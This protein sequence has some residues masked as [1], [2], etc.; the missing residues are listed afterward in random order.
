[1]DWPREGIFSLSS[2]FFLPSSILKN[3]IS[4]YTKHRISYG[5]EAIRIESSRRRRAR[6]GSERAERRDVFLQKSLLFAHYSGASLQVLLSLSAD[7][8]LY[9]SIHPTGRLTGIHLL[10]LSW[11]VGINRTTL[12]NLGFVP[13]NHSLGSLW[14]TSFAQLGPLLLI[15]WSD[16]ASMLYR[17]WVVVVSWS[18]D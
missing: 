12:E 16:T 6:S 11:S 1:M 9:H 17:R 13:T 14:L 8:Q 2:F 5:F 15:S 10:L 18:H 4:G 3:Q 7:W